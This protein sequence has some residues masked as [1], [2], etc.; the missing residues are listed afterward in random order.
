MGSTTDPAAGNGKQLWQ[1]FTWKD[2]PK[3]EGAA[4]DGEIGQ[5]LMETLSFHPKGKF[6]LM[7]GRL[8]KGNWNA[9]LFD[10]ESGSRL[11]Q[12]NIGFR[13]STSA[14]TP[15]GKRLFLGGGANQGRPNEEK[16]WGRIVIYDVSS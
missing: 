14:F 3:K 1:K 11:Y 12:K 8:F 5:G 13:I 9:A 6:F 2:G 10:H 15:D 16:K 7:A 4:A